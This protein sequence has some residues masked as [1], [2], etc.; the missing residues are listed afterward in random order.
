MG[1]CGDKEK[2]QT[3]RKDEDVKTYKIVVIGDSNVGKTAI[4]HQFLHNTFSRDAQPTI[5]VKNQ[6]KFV[7][8]P[9][10]ARLKLD[11]WDTAGN[12]STQAYNKTF[13]AGAHAVLIVYSI[14]S[15]DTFKSID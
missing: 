15:N 13:F 3:Q 4:I 9:D 5:G 11:I 1:V 2:N 14:D 7:E 10:G 12:E 8:L 6:Y